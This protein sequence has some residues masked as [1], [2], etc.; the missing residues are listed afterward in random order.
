[1]YT[2]RKVGKNRVS[3][4][5]KKVKLLEPVDA[6]KINIVRDHY[7]EGAYLIDFP[8]DRTPDH[9]WQDIF[10]REWRSSRRLWD[11]KLFIINDKLRLITTPDELEE[12]I[13]WI[14]QVIQQTNEEI[15]E[16][17]RT[18]PIEKQLKKTIR[19]AEEKTTIETVRTVL[20]EKLGSSGAR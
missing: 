8:L 11:R 4:H 6:D 18:A 10:D 13:D 16:Y 1:M 12:K 2:A 20:K 7:F 3:R 15:D 5:S 17:N 19:L 14:K 9:T